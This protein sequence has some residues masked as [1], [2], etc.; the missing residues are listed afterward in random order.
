[1][2]SSWCKL[3][4][5]GWLWRSPGPLRI[6]PGG[7]RRCEQWPL[8]LAQAGQFG[9]MFLVLQ[10]LNIYNYLI[11]MA[12][13]LPELKQLEPVLSL[14]K[15]FVKWFVLLVGYGPNGTRYMLFLATTR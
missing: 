8:S 15:W 4:I 2:A 1:M 12:Q 14:R 3:G 9:K 7:T 13:G 10:P 5:G 11:S 6:P